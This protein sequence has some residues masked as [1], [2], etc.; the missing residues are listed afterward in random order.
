MVENRVESNKEIAVSQ[1]VKKKQSKNTSKLLKQ[2]EK[3][4][5]VELL[6]TWNFTLKSKSF[7]F[8]FSWFSFKKFNYKIFFYWVTNSSQ[9][10]VS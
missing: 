1:T 5:P 4:V 10:L 3:N 8:L 6:F 9:I 2:L 7:A